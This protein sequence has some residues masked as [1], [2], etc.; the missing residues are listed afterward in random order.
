MKRPEIK[1]LF[2]AI[3]MISLLIFAADVP[4][5]SCA[6]N[7]NSQ[8][9]LARQ[10]HKGNG[11]PK[12]RH[13]A[14]E[15][16]KEAA[17]KGH[18]VA[19]FYM[20]IYYD[21]GYIFDKDLKKA[22]YWY[23]KAAN[24]G[25]KNAQYNLA[26]MYHSG[27]GIPQN[28]EKAFELY[29]KAAEQGHSKSQYKVGLYHDEGYISEPN[30][31]KASQWYEKAAMED[32]IKAQRN[33]GFVYWGY[34]DKSMKD[35][36]KAEWCFLMASLQEDIRSMVELG[37]LYVYQGDQGKGQLYFDRGY[38]WLNQAAYEGNA[39]AMYLVG[40][41][42]AKGSGMKKDLPQAEK[43][44]HKAAAEGSEDAKKILA[45]ID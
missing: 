24:Q 40:L 38:Y 42:Y 5:A 12:D 13:K 1:S 31:R 15:L 41:M 2:L 16:F 26:N 21:F 36:E 32:H 30:Y 43:W 19:Q 11:K 9:K 3:L 28:R 25:Q 8:Y 17:Q 27:R 44:F 18:R 35:L 37:L 10:Y 6:Q 7:G 29:R 45:G 39:R 22:A 23:E 34:G 14:F 33:L 4:P 20:G